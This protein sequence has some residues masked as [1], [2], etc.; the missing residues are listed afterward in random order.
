MTLTIPVIKEIVTAIAVKHE[1]K[2]VFLFGS[3]A[4]GEETEESDVDLRVEMRTAAPWSLTRF[5]ADL[6]ESLDTSVDI[7]ETDGAPDYL[8]A[9]IKKEEVLIYECKQ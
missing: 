7:I 4:R 6:V 9:E 3:Y 5:Y 2:E 1:V 8:L